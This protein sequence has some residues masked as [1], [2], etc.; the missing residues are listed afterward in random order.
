MTTVAATLCSTDPGRLGFFTNPQRES[1]TRHPSRA[2]YSASVPPASLILASRSPRR[3]QLLAEHGFAAHEAVHPG[4]EDA[5]L[6]PSTSNPAAWVASLAYLKAWAK[7]AEPAS[8]GRI[9]LG[10]D[11]ACLLDGRLIGTPTTPQEAGSMIRALLNREHEVLTGVAVIDCRTEHPTRYI[12]TDTA[13]VRL[14]RLSD[15]QIADY[16]ASGAWQG[17]AGGY[18][19]REALAS[20]WPLSHTGDVTTI[21][22]L[23]MARLSGLLTR[24]GV[25]QVQRTK[26]PA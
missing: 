22:G 12:F 17:K 2:E 14:G 25:P 11:T 18:N 10:A 16:A 23:P 26:V 19:Y 4:F 9:V 20:G 1:S 8:R 21:M 5:A 24:L 7:A 13:R 3:R 6:S 15:G